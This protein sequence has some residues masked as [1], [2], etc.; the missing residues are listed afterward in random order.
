VETKR[1]RNKGEKAKTVGNAV[2]QINT[3]KGWLVQ[4]EKKQSHN[5]KEEALKDNPDWVG[6]NPTKEEKG[7]VVGTNEKNAGKET[8]NKKQNDNT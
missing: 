7:R 5:K 4:K 1:E 8:K 2:R 3:K 6:K